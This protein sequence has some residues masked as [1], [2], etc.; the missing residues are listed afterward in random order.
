MTENILKSINSA[1][2]HLSNKGEAPCEIQLIP[3]GDMV[4]V[5]GR[6]F[7]LASAEDVIAASNKIFGYSD[8]VIDYEHQTEYTN[9]NGQPAPASGW[10]KSLFVRDGSVWG[11]V[12]WTDKAL[13]HIKNK[14]YRYI[15]P[16][17]VH[18]KSG[19][20][21]SLES[22]ALTNRPNLELK[23]L[24]SSQ[25]PLKE[26]NMNPLKDACAALGLAENA[27]SDEVVKAITDLS[28]KAANSAKSLSEIAK[29]VKSE[30]EDAEAIIK[31][32]NSAATPNPAEYVS[33]E[34]FTALNTQLVDL[35]N[36]INKESAEKAVNSAISGGKLP[37]SLKENALGIY[38]S[39]GADAFNKFVEGM[40]KMALNSSGIP[41]DLPSNDNAA[42][43]DVEKAMCSAMGVAEADFIKTRA[44][45][46]Q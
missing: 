13:N 8:I 5:D 44:G 11:K 18:K 38:E 35:S 12:E 42:L 29:A 33:M 7:S 36:R 1:K 41:S 16:V 28:N 4:G 21:I 26:T 14:E 23:A 25:Q 34:K 37:P 40:P 24:N 2:I 20:V 39:A 17:I 45:E 19:E 3:A 32:A 31:A 27:T 10:I 43:S 9:K 22:A 46:K 15:S 30:K 6:A